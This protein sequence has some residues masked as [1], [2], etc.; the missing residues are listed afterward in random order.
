MRIKKEMKFDRI[1]YNLKCKKC[2]AQVE[3]NPDDLHYVGGLR[4]AWTCPVCYY[5][6]AE[7][8]IGLRTKK[9]I[10][11]TPVEDEE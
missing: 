5:V 10:V 1:E 7:T 4:L 6:N 9:A 2:D 3:A 11:Y 8:I